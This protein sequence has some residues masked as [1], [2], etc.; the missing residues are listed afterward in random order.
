MTTQ[1]TQTAQRVRIGSDYITQGTQDAQMIRDL[2]PEMLD[3][4]GARRGDVYVFE[5]VE[6]TLTTEMA[7]TW[8]HG[9]TGQLVEKVTVRTEV[10]TAS[11]T[12]KLWRT[13][14][15]GFYWKA[16]R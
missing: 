9:F 2:D 10:V 15:R 12:L 5:T 7:P 6:V 4:I 1:A 13:P 8:L 14:S 3:W 16:T 11:E